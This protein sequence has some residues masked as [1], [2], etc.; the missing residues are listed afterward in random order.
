MKR[1]L[2][3]LTIKRNR[4]SMELIALR[5]GHC[6]CEHIGQPVFSVGEFEMIKLKTRPEKIYFDFSLHRMCH[7]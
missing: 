2:A 1:F 7:L 6:L 5:V 4:I 3:Q